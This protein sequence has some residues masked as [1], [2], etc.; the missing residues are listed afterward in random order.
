MAAQLGKPIT[1]QEDPSLL[2]HMEFLK[3]SQYAL[4]HDAYG[5]PYTTL[6]RIVSGFRGL[7]AQAGSG[8]SSDPSIDIRALAFQTDT[9][10]LHC[11]HEALVGFESLGYAGG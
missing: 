3:R 6:L 2:S 1:I 4:P 9:E 10:I 8:N 11:Q 5:S 7:F